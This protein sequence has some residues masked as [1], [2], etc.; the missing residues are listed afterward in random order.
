VAA[1]TAKKVSLYLYP[2]WAETACK[3]PYGP[4]LGCGWLTRIVIFN[5][6]NKLYIIDFIEYFI[7]I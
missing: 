6:I 2:V 5:K 1:K 7:S 4:E 3:A